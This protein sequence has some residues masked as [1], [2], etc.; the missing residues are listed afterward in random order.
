MLPDGAISRSKAG[1][2]GGYWHS[3]LVNNLPA[4]FDGIR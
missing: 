2:V 4:R 1:L 3:G